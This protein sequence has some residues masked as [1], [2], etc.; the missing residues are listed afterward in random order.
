MR[1]LRALQCVTVASFDQGV[2]GTGFRKPTTIMLVRLGSF[3]NAVMMKGNN[4][5]CNHANHDVLQG[6]QGDGSICTSRAKVYPPPGLNNLLGRAIMDFIVHQLEM[7]D[8]EE[9]PDS[10]ACFCEDLVADNEVVQPDFHG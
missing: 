10:V 2:F 9:L 5:R 3:R 1:R 6:K 7:K 4:G 8:T